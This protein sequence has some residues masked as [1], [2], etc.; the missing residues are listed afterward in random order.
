MKKIRK[1]AVLR[2]LISLFL[3]LLVSF[4]ANAQTIYEGTIK[5]K[6]GNPIPF[7]SLRIVGDNLSFVTDSLGRFSLSNN[8]KYFKMVISA[9]GYRSRQEVFHEGRPTLIIVLDQL[10]N[11]ID[12]VVINTGYQTLPKERATGSFGQVTNKVLNTMTTVNL[13]ERL[14]GKVAGL[15]FDN[16]SGKSEINVRG[17]NTFNEG[18]S[19]PLI[20]LDNF[21]Y[22]GSLE[23]INPNDIESVTVLKDAAASSIWGA[24]AGNG[25]I[26]ITSKKGSEEKRI[27]AYT[28]TMVTQ[29]PDIF[30]AQ[31]IS[32]SDFIAVERMLF[33]KGFYDAPYNSSANLNIVFSPVVELLYANKSGTVNDEEL[34]RKIKEWSG[35]DYRKDFSKYLLRNG[36]GQQYFVDLESKS[37]NNQMRASVGYDRQTGTQVP[38]S[39]QRFSFKVTNETKLGKK[40]KLTSIVTYTESNNKSSANFPDYSLSPAGTRNRIYPYAELIDAQGEPLV[41]PN[42]IN[43]NFADSAG[44]GKLLDWKYKPIEDPEKSLL[45]RWLR[46]LV[47][48]LRLQY[49]LWEP[50]KAELTYGYENQNGNTSTN[51]SEESYYVRDLI[52][53]YSQIVNGQVKY[54]IPTG[55]ILKTSVEGMQSHRIRGQLNFNKNWNNLHDL[56]IL[57]GSEVSSTN[58]ANDSYGVYGYDKDVMTNKEVD[59]VTRFPIYGNISGDRVIPSFSGYSDQISRFVSVYSNLQY[60]FLERYSLS[61]SVRKDGSNSFGSKTNSRW[62]PLWS[63]GG[64]WQITKER[65]MKNMNWIDLLK[66]RATIGIGG[67]TIPSSLTETMLVYVGKSPYSGLQY[68]RVINPPNPN[69]KWE[70]VRMNNYGLDF[71]ILGNKLSGAI[72]YYEKRSYDILSTDVIDPTSGF[73]SMPKN[74][75]EIKSKGIDVSLIAHLDI[76]KLN[77]V[78]QVN[79]SH[80][81]NTITRYKGG[82]GETAF[83]VNGGVFITPI[84]GKTLYP[85]FSYRSAGLDPLTGDPRGYLNGEISKDYDRMIADSLQYLNFHGT[86]LPPYYGT[87]N[88]SFSY[89]GFNLNVSLLFKWGH[90][91]RKESIAYSS[92]YNTWVGHGDFVKRWQKEGDERETTV[93]SMTFP[94][95]ENRD[96]FYLKS[97]ANI[98]KGDLIRIQSIRLSYN[99]IKKSKYP[100]NANVFIGA[101]NLGVIWKKAKSGLD[102]DFL[103][104]PNP[105]VF[106]VGVN[107]Q[108]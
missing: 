11:R 92:L 105:R 47:A 87:F 54:I 28:N 20:V 78:P 67:N 61:V 93:P 90:Y 101:N 32:S 12:E 13:M 42:G 58:S 102:P 25:V 2:L 33:E 57:M 37:Q 23:N 29:K 46:H 81:S 82:F 36:I 108:L 77:W 103:G 9:I 60:N 99:L 59:Y 49:Q 50:L 70:T 64:S 18:S 72:E 53:R 19:K 43:Q 106:T 96:N 63:A 62:N 26:V 24:R 56:N 22:E 80:A 104:M 84:E 48:S 15:Q 6:E 55:D 69:L 100:I 85:V 40:A 30:Y 74:V 35:K 88:N 17:L 89:N 52:N 75:G 107:F 83:Y 71:G 10:E 97:E 34:E 91:F 73:V 98:G 45:N 31:T 4:N 51:F 66:L 38:S 3:V 1:L 41:V 7:A 27:N 76:G 68:A 94:A 16:R 14:E 65:F 5:N 44:S 8:G 86:A 39:N 79:F 21:P 95:D